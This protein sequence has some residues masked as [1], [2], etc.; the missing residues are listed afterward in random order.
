MSDFSSALGLSTSGLRAQAA[1]LRHLSENIANADTPGYRRKTVSFHADASGSGTVETGPVNLAQTPLKKVFDP[2]HPLADE[3]GHFAGSNVDLLIEIT[4][5]R[6]AQRSYEANL[7]MFD[8][9]R[10]MSSSLMELLRK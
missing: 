9:T 10:Q 3:T 2:N 6:E 1:R 4:D 5:A 7:K 8:Q